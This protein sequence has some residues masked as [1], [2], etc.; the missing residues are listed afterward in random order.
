MCFSAQE[1]ARKLISI[2]ST[3]P[4]CFE[5]ELEAHLRSHIEQLCLHLPQSL[6]EHIFIQEYEVAPGRK[7]IMCAFDPYP[8]APRTVFICHMDTVV[9]GTGWSENKAPFVPVE[10]EDRLY[11]RGSCD[12]KGGLACALTAFARYLSSIN[13][14]DLASMTRGCAFIGTVD[15]EATMQGV[16]AVCREGWTRSEDWVLD[17][18]PTDG[19]IQVAHKGRL[20]IEVKAKGVTA[21]ASQPW[22]GVDANHALVCALAELY[23]AWKDLPDHAELGA[24]TLTVGKIEGGYQPF[25]V[26][27]KAK[28]WLDIRLAPPTDTKRVLD[29]L[30]KAC[31]SAAS[32]VPSIAFSYEVLGDRPAI[33]KDPRSPLLHLLSQAVEEVTHQPAHIGIFTGY[34]DTAVIAGTQGNSNCM[35]YGPGSLAQ[36]HKP[37][38]YVPLEDLVRCEG[39]LYDL[40]KRAERYTS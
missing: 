36:A 9:A 28:A 31:E 32:E 14:D 18:E 27:D 30:V 40:L 38:E 34:T 3:N 26:A 33:E 35:S 20:W 24:S 19:E 17:T 25:V 16:E 2:E 22:E 12:M 37:D 15:E 8:S 21:H 23:R 11:G 29:M 5:T 13:P 1:L 7:N 6:Q 10:E 39:V 4:G